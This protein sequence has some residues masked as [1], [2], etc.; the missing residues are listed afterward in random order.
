MPVHA[1][2]SESDKSTAPPL[3][4]LGGST[5]AAAGSAL[6]AGF[7]PICAAL[8][9]DADLHRLATVLP[10]V[11]YPR[12]LRDAAQQAPDCPWMYT[13]ALENR[14]TLLEQIAA[15][16]TGPLWG[17]PSEVLR[18]VRD[19]L[20]VAES[21]RAAGLPTLAVRPA[22]DPPPPDGR[23][24]RKPLHSAAGRLIRVWDEIA[25]GSPFPEPCWFQ[26]FGQ[27]IP[28]SA[29]YLAESNGCELL[30]VSRQLVGLASAKAAP[31]G[32]CGSIGPFPLDGSAHEQVR[33]FGDV[34][35]MRFHLRGLFGIDFLFDGSSLRL[36]EINPR[37]TASVEVLELALGTSIL[38]K[39]GAAFGAV[40]GAASQPSPST[41]PRC[42]PHH[43][44]V[45]KQL[46]FAD[47][48]LRAPSFERFLPPRDP[49]ILPF[50]ADLPRGGLR[51]EPGQPI[52][53]VFARAETVNACVAKLERRAAR[54]F[55]RLSP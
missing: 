10:V 3:L 38:H 20:L 54:I 17:N 29:C 8:F 43:P 49:W 19:P 53:T 11:D 24:L 9:A 50:L 45:G 34:V 52:C 44:V 48:T 30:G 22:S 31:F 37:Y 16:R 27:G 32:Y 5:R 35:R 21:L 26:E 47:R 12:G 7:Q 2:S 4:I 13:G 15:D 51:I 39:L 41:S 23:W 28:I 18:R 6:R 1:E 46:L 42:G 33:R 55:A 36:V 40:F 25:E 14:P